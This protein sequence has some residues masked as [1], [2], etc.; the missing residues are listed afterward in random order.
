MDGLTKKWGDFL[1]N[2]DDVTQ[3][4]EVISEIHVA[5]RFCVVYSKKFE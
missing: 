5:R 1:N 3:R 2:N 4:L